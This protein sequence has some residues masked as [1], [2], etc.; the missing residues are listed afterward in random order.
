M[1]AAGR[2]DA[3]E[4]VVGAPHLVSASAAEVCHIDVSEVAPEASP[5]A[6]AETAQ[7]QPHSAPGTERSRKSSKRLSREQ[8]AQMR[9]FSQEQPHRSEQRTQ[10][11]GAQR[12]GMGMRK[13]TTIPCRKG[14]RNVSVNPSRFRNICGFW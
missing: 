4:A 7:T 1:R 12:S 6:S 8:K 14:F 11:L 9:R 10:L 2:A 3:R 5:L 13:K